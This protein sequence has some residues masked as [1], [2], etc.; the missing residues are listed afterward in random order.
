MFDT[1]Q[2]VI[3]YYAKG[4]LN[5][6]EVIYKKFDEN[7]T[8]KNADLSKAFNLGD[9]FGEHSFCWNWHL[10]V[11]AMKPAFSFLEIGVY[12]GR[13]LGVIQIL[14]NQM[15]KKAS[16]IGITPLTNQGDK[17]ST[18]PNENYSNSL[19]NNLTRMGINDID[20]INIIKG[21]SNDKASIEEASASS[22]FDI[23]FIDGCHDYEVVCQDIKNYVPML[24]SG[25]YLVMDDASLLLE[26]PFG[27][28]LGHKDVCQAI[29]DTID[30]DSSLK[31]VFAVGHNRVWTKL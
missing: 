1:L 15:N 25:G 11:E 17:Y 8:T 20:S 29:K 2:E 18:Y 13:T 10:L 22:Q 31:H 6:H 23:I 19:L 3:D 16:I 14:A 27:Q 21:F 24:K 28:F 7:V 4:E 9:G 26:K 30:G 5:R 12:K